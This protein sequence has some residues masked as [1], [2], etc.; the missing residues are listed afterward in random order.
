[1]FAK[2]IS[3]NQLTVDN[4]VALV[5]FFCHSAAL[6]WALPALIFVNDA[7]ALVHITFFTDYCL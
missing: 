3:I 4:A 7:V 1:M 2:G 6:P 5:F